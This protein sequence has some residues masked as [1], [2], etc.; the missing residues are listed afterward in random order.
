MLLGSSLLTT[1][2]LLPPTCEMSVPH[3]HHFSSPGSCSF[4]HSSLRYTLNEYQDVA[5]RG[6]QVSNKAYI[7]REL[8]PSTTRR[9]EAVQ[10]LSLAPVWEDAVT[11]E[12][13]AII[14]MKPDALFDHLPSSPGQPDL[15]VNKSGFLHKT[16]T[17]VQAEVIELEKPERLWATWS[18]FSTLVHLRRI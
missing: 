1:P 9:D 12:N 10:S 13:K 11:V 2:C 5:G 18:Q 4:M 3:S 15:N 17:E 7:G 6:C 16:I 8:V 14:R